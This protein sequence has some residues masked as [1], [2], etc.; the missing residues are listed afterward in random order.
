MSSLAIPRLEFRGRVTLARVIHSEWTKLRSVRSTRWS[1]LVAT[2]LTIGFPILA[3]AVISSHW[4]HRSPGERANFNALNPALIGSQIAQ[5]AIGVL[6]VLVISGEYSTG[7]IRASFTAVPKRLPVL[8]AKVFVFA[9]VTFVPMLPAVLIAFFASQ[10]ILSRHHVQT[11]FSSP[12]VARAV[13]GAALYLTVVAV[14]SLSLG[15]ILRNTAGGIATFAAILFVIP[16]LMNVLPTSWNDAASRYLPSNAGRAILSVT[17]DPSNLAPWTGF[18]VF[19][20]Y[21]AGA[22]AIAAVLLVRRDT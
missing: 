10:S 20:A 13:I 12:H 21:A 15:T 8:W 1:L 14:F 2:V 17:K 11:T 9:L 3:S 16:P 6:G 4:D 19:C 5:L 7:M 18:G 22:L